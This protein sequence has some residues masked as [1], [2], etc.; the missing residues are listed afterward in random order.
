MEIFIKY[1]IVRS[2][3]SIALCNNTAKIEDSIFWATW[4]KIPVQAYASRLKFNYWNTVR[5]RST[6][7][8]L[9]ISILHTCRSH[10]FVSCILRCSNL[11]QYFKGLFQYAYSYKIDIFT[12]VYPIF[13][14]KIHLNIWIF[15]DVLS[16][17]VSCF[18][19][20]YQFVLSYRAA[21]NLKE[22]NSRIKRLKLVS[23]RCR[24]TFLSIYSRRVIP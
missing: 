22:K 16:L 21:F 14:L 17:L 2:I 7:Y 13:H 12:L 9:R 6:L 15:P 20:N 10:A 5:N 23:C 8:C 11:R 3:R 24:W 1:L 19:D 18:P 4:N